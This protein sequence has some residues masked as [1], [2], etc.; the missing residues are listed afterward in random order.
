MIEEDENN[1]NENNKELLIATD[2]NIDKSN[3]LNIE[4]INQEQIEEPEQIEE[5]EKRSCCC[6][7]YLFCC[8]CC[9]SKIK[10]KDF[11]KKNWKKYLYK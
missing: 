9:Y 1:N 10:T 5:Y 4:L 2:T 3:K 11:Y 7:F 8:C 6:C